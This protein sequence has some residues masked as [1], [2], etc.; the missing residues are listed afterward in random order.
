MNKQN[1]KQNKKVPFK[2]E[3]LNQCLGVTIF[4]INTMTKACQGEKGLFNC[5][6]T[7]LLVVKGSQGRNSDRAEAWMQ[8]DAK[9]KECWCSLVCSSWLTLLAF[10]ERRTTG[11][12]MAHLQWAEPPQPLIKKMSHELAHTQS[13]GAISSIEASQ[14]V[15][16]HHFVYLAF[17]YYFYVYHTFH[18]ITKQLSK[19][20]YPSYK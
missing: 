9:A 20:S 2:A 12:G 10:I 17:V 4:M 1:I 8:G 19:H 11:L 5:A 7:S 6:C 15:K 16:I 14:T 13:Q 3:A 18:T